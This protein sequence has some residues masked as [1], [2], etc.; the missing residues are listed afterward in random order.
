MKTPAPPAF[1]LLLTRQFAQ[2]AN[3]LNVMPPVHQVKLSPFRAG[4]RPEDYVIEQLDV[5]SKLL[6]LARDAPVH[7]RDLRPNFS[8]YSL[9]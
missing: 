2:P 3:L 6:F 1:S 8:H 7:F 5:L 4:Q 9:V